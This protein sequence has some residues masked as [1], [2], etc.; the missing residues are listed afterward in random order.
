M[1][2]AWSVSGIPVDDDE[3]YRAST[4]GEHASVV[5]V[6]GIRILPVTR[7]ANAHT[8]FNCWVHRLHGFGKQR[9]VAAIGHGRLLRC[10]SSSQPALVP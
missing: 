6:T 2:I 4:V 1:F 10:I 9:D 8:N 3:V 5:G 7:Q